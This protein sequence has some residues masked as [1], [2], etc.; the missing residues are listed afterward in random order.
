MKQGAELTTAIV[1]LLTGLALIP[2]IIVLLRKKRGPL[3]E[4]WTRLLI[5]LSAAH[6]GGFIAHAFLW[7]QPA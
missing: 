1:D 3:A 5:A 2:F 4:G 6:V 7:N